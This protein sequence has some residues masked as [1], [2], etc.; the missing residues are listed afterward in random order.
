VDG[1]TARGDVARLMNNAYKVLTTVHT[2]VS[3]SQLEAFVNIW[4]VSPFRA[5]SLVAAVEVSPRTPG[6]LHPKG[7]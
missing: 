7:T 2:G 1:L 3:L 6:T 4:G 5:I